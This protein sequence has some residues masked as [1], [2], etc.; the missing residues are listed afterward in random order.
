MFPPNTDDGKKDELSSYWE[1][2]ARGLADVLMHLN[3]TW[4]SKDVTTAVLYSNERSNLEAKYIKPL[5]YGAMASL[6]LF[7]N[8]RIT[9]SSSFQSWRKNFARQWTRHNHNPEKSKPPQPSQPTKSQ[10]TTKQYGPGYLHSKRQRDIQEAMESMRIIS[11]LLVSVSVGVSGALFMLHG[12]SENMREDWETAPLVQGKSVVAQH[13]CP[14]MIR[15]GPPSFPRGGE[16]K[17]GI[18]DPMFA[19]KDYSNHEMFS[20]VVSNC[21][22]RKIMEDS[23]RKQ[24]GLAAT[25]SVY[26]PFPGVR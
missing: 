9:G 12:K 15:L 14:S 16:E 18:V 6:F 8:F 22:K 4:Y 1:E 26:V 10:E 3:E 11:D 5:Q 7:L 20:R 17:T 25:T 23:I 19:A 24:K 21:Q 2:T 13:V